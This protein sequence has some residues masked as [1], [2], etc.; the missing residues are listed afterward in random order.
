M[1]ALVLIVAGF[2]VGLSLALF[3]GRG[4]IRQVAVAIAGLLLWSAWSIYSL[5][6]DCSAGHECTQGLGAFLG[7]FVLFG[8]LA[9]VGVAALVW[10]DGSRVG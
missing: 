7:L 4:W 1:L 2:I 5:V 3:V 9:G 8:W 10:R 6:V